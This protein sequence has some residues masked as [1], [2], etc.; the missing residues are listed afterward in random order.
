M[1]GIAD[2]DPASQMIAPLFK[3]NAQEWTDAWVPE[4]A[5]WL[6][7]I[8]AGFL[9]T[10]LGSSVAGLLTGLGLLAYIGLANPAGRDREGMM[11][12]AAHF[13]T[14]PGAAGFFGLASAASATA[15]GKA[16]SLAALQQG[17]AAGNLDMVR[18]AFAFSPS[19]L[20]SYFSSLGAQFTSLFT[21]VTPGAT[22]A[23]GIAG[24]GA[25]VPAAPMTAP[26]TITSLIG[27]GQVF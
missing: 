6:E 1:A 4:L 5:V 8:P 26:Q 2:L 27:F 19:D 18:S 14:H 3:T 23:P 11:H 25:P 7:E 13:V 9:L 16:Q 12:G 17:I 10:G 21:P 15:L 22:A 20:S 24:A